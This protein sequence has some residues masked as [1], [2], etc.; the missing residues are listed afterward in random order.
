MPDL[1][2]NGAMD[3]MEE[4]SAPKISEKNNKIIVV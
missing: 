1:V 3:R 4:D 2:A